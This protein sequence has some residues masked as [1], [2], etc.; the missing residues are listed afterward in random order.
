MRT[1]S[2]FFAVL[3]LCCA[4]I[5]FAQDKLFEQYADMDNVTSVF[6]S[7]KMFD[8]MPDIETGDLNLKDLRGKID[9]LQILTTEKKEIQ[10]QMQKDF[11]SLITQSHEE[12]MRVKD[13]KDKVT[14][15]VR[16][17]D[18]GLIREMLMLV[19]S[20][21][22]FVVIRLNGKFTPEDIRK[23]TEQVE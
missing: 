21:S 5:G 9:N 20:D 22:E 16:Q 11:S 2:I 19:D 6:I 14:F 18:D 8:L 3:L 17:S 23:I 1:R 12:L 4:S 15:Y 10:E 13:G 7:K